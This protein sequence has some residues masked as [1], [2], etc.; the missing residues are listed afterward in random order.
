MQPLQLPTDQRRISLPDKLVSPRKARLKVETMQKHERR[1]MSQQF[2][3]MR[4]IEKKDSGVLLQDRI[5]AIQP[6]TTLGRRQSRNSL[7]VNLSSAFFSDLSQQDELHKA[8]KLCIEIYHT[9]KLLKQSVPEAP[10]PL[11]EQ[12]SVLSK[13]Y[14]LGLRRFTENDVSLSL[15]TILGAM[16]RSPYCKSLLDTREELKE[17]FS[18]VSFKLKDYTFVQEEVQV[19]ERLLKK[20]APALQKILVR[21]GEYQEELI[22]EFPFMSFI[23]G[24]AL[25]DIFKSGLIKEKDIPAFFQKLEVRRSGSLPLE[26][27]KSKMAYLIFN[28][29][30]NVIVYASAMIPLEDV[31][32]Q[33]NL[34]VLHQVT[35]LFMLIKG[36]PALIEDEEIT[37][38][39][40][41]ALSQLGKIKERL[42]IA[43]EEIVLRQLKMDPTLNQI[44]MRQTLLEAFP[45]EKAK[46]WNKAFSLFEG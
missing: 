29:N 38:K 31:F 28:P 10:I 35:H 11:G 39:I 46:D 41:L 16:Y 34:K 4:S 33:D 21:L 27:L 8:N 20:Y 37:V 36:K 12:L 9:W 45:E 14:D 1:R 44:H 6:T 5:T 18:S 17:Q 3:E 7:V 19:L 24:V 15:S 30:K 13:Y 23:N 32:S 2:E 26:Y 25:E 42:H 43:I 40:Q 22:Q